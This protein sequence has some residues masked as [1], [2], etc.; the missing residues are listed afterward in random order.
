MV[1]WNYR[2]FGD[3][4]NGVGPYKFIPPHYDLCT[5]HCKTSRFRVAKVIGM[6]VSIAEA[7]TF[8]KDNV[9][10]KTPKLYTLEAWLTHDPERC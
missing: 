6:L 9:Y 3:V 1:I 4:S 2:I 5:R 8:G 10:A 7:S